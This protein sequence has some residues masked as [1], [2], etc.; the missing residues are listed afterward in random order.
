MKAKWPLRAATCAGALTALRSSETARRSQQP[1]PKAAVTV[2]SRPGVPPGKSKAWPGK[3]VREMLIEAVEK[4]VGTVESVHSGHK[5]EFLSNNGGAYIATQTRQMARA[6]GLKP[7][8]TPVCSPQSNGMAE[9]FV[10]TFRRDYLSRMDL[11]NA[12]A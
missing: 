1:L 4:R 5:L 2:K 7:I 6:L 11:S 12:P 8:N 3:Q 10:N 9:S